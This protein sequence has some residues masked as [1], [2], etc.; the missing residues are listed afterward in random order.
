[1]ANNLG[2]FLNYTNSEVK[3]NINLNN[4]NNLK[5]NFKCIIV[6]DEDNEISDKLLENIKEMVNNSK[7]DLINNTIN[8][9]IHIKYNSSNKYLDIE[10]IIFTLKDRDCS[11]YNNIVFISDSH[12]YLNSLKDY[13][14]YINNYNIDLCSY[15]DSSENEYHC[16][17]YLFSIKSKCI[18]NFLNFIELEK[19]NPKFIYKF[20][21][22]FEKSIPFLK[23]AYIQDNSYK[24]IFY[25]KN[26]YKYFVKN[27]ILPVI[28]LVLLNDYT[29]TYNY[30]TFEIL[31]NNFDLEIYK[32][33]EDLK[34]FSDNFLYNHFLEYGQFEFRKYS[35]DEDNI[36]FILPSFIRE[37]LKENNLLQF[38]DV[39]D[40][41]NLYSYKKKYKDLEDLDENRLI[42]HWI[43]Y[44]YYEKRS[45][46]E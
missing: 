19:D 2:I 42:M 44:G 45:Y 40:D 33:N 18:N 46:K 1:M 20:P 6:V 22:I 43:K 5:D 14:D 17:L 32:S 25:N 28:D 21:K 8:D 10:K 29:N 4:Y 12:I 16:Q 41:F 15:N 39:P 11:S 27:D 26:L 7:K 37:K 9:T 30:S 38:Y 36:N 3:Y 31:P 35:D 34:N 13:F 23:I 24:N